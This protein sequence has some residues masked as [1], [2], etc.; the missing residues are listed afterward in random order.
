[1]NILGFLSLAPGT[2]RYLNHLQK[3]C[4][5]VNG[6]HLLYFRLDELHKLA[7][8]R[9]WGNILIRIRSGQRNQ[10]DAIRIHLAYNYLL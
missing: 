6:F 7:L 8:T 2:G 9:I 10:C 4:S 3:G 5:I 1:M